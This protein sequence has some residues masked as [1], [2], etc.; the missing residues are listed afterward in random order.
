MSGSIY[1]QTQILLYFKTKAII[2]S[3][4][5]IT[6]RHQHNILTQTTSCSRS[7]SKS[8]LDDE[9]PDNQEASEQNEVDG[10]KKGADST[11]KVM[12]M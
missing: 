11:G 9:N 2:I 10:M 12:H 8:R 7:V 3:N 5:K 6:P 4:T 1:F